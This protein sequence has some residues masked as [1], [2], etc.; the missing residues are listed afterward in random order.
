M[1][2]P[3]KGAHQNLSRQEGYYGF[4]QSDSIHT[5]HFHAMADVPFRAFKNGEFFHAQGDLITYFNPHFPLPQI[6]SWREYK[7]K[8]KMASHVMSCL[9]G[10]QLKMESLH[11]LPKHGNIIGST[12]QNTVRPSNSHHILVTDQPAK[13]LSCSQDLPPVY[14]PGLTVEK[15]KSAYKRSQTRSRPSPRPANWFADK[16]PTSKLR[17]NTFFPSKKV[18]EGF[19]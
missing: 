11:K 19:H 13:K 18:V 10:T 16:V 17:E 9:H 5:N 8:T 7:V 4:Y 1:H 6:L 2:G 15:I 12:G 14:G 3:T